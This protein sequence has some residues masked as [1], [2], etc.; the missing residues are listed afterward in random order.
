M[1]SLEY[2]PVSTTNWRG[3]VIKIENPAGS[4]RKGISKNGT[5]WETVMPYDYGFVDGSKGVDGDEVDVFLGPDKYAKYVYIMKQ[6]K[7]ESGEFDEDKCFLGFQDEMDAK[8][9]YKKAYDRPELFIG[10]METLPFEVFKKRVLQTKDNPSFIHASS[11]MNTIIELYANEVIEPIKTGSVVSVP[12]LQGKGIV[13]GIVGRRATIKF[14]SG[15][16]VS[17]DIGELT[18]IA[19]RNTSSWRE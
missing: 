15:E 4:V 12:G 18:N 2:K 17:R 1:P 9:A 7:K 16:Y 3:L 14:R 13:I 5:E 10:K 6:L 11:K 19:N 8:E